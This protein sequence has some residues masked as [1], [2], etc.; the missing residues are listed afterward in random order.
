MIKY[1]YAISQVVTKIGGKIM[2]L[3]TDIESGSNVPEEITVVV[4]I[5]TGSRNKY[6]YD[7]EKEA[8]ALDRVLFFTIPLPCRIWFHAKNHYGRMEILLM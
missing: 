7:K 5:P 1:H 4:E 3:W 8:L 6:E 2:N